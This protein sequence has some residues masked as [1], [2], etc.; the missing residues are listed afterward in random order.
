MKK[1][2]YGTLRLLEEIA[3]FF[4][5]TL[6]IGA[7][8]DVKNVELYMLKRKFGYWDDYFFFTFVYVANVANKTYLRYVLFSSH[9]NISKR[10]LKILSLVCYWKPFKLIVLFEVK[11]LM[12]W[13]LM[14]KADNNVV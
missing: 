6:V 2:I 7:Y 10:I 11:G 12:S 4:V 14:R 8:F 9:I 13:L 1:N 5:F 3:V